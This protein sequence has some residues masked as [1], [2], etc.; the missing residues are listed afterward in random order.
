LAQVD[1]VASEHIDSAFLTQRAQ[2]HS[3]RALGELRDAQLQLEERC[4]RERLLGERLRAANDLESAAQALVRDRQAEVERYSAFVAD[5]QREILQL[6]AQVA[7]RQQEVERLAA[8][9]TVLQGSR[10]WRL[11]QALRAPFGRAW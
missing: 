9:L 10:A 1:I 2:E 4:E 7:D 11:I 8:F 5:R 3:G 6:K